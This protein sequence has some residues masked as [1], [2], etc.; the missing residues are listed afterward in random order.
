MSETAR[1]PAAIETVASKLAA[2]GIHARPG[3]ERAGDAVSGVVPS[4]VATPA[5]TAGVESAMA[6]ANRHGLAVVAR[7]NGSK[8]DWG[9]P[10]RR[11]DMTVATTALTGITHASGDLV[12]RVGAGTPLAQLQ[13]E[14]ATAGQR[15]SVDT[16]IAGSTVGGVVATGLSGPRRLLHGSVRDLVIG[17]TV[18]GADAVATSSGGAV[19]KNVAGY[20]LAKLH[21]GALG[22]L[23]V[24]TSVT[25]RLHPIAP[26][27][28]LVRA[29]TSDPAAARAWVWDMA[30]SPAVASAVELDWPAGGALHLYV[31][32]EGTVAGVEARAAAVA[33]SL[34]GGAAEPD[35]RAD[36]PAGWGAAPGEDGDT[37]LRVSCPIAA[38]VDTALALRSAGEAVG[39]PVAVR[40]S[41]GAGVL[42]A[43]VPA[44]TA[45][46]D[47]AT[48]V[49]RVRTELAEGS[50]TVARPA[51]AVRGSGLDL[52]GEVAGLELMRAVKDSFDPGHH[53]APG[54]FVGGI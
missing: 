33:A 26:A 48:I 6:L 20:D 28:R 29:T 51:A 43:S 11:L 30:R 18:V 16:V 37:L 22:T 27:L 19:V 32:L 4:L 31:L 40:G 8:I 17:M 47:V 46:A 13:E 1:A 23:G 9:A 7:G 10:P 15:L 42:L 12:A 41:A 35:T 49:T 14:L 39:V 45:A 3:E 21:T 24:I 36:L 52:W 54:R 5:D 50:V 2:H 25:F 34:R 53:L 44:R 38:T